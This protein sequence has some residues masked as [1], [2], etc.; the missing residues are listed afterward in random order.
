MNKYFGF[1]ELKAASIPTVPWERFSCESILDENLLW[2]IRVAVEDSNDLNLPR[3]IGAKAEEAQKTGR[4]YLKKYSDNGLVIYY[5][6]FLADKSGVLEISSKRIVIEAV[7]KD[8]WNLVTYGKRDVTIII[9]ALQ[10]NDNADNNDKSDYNRNTNNNDNAYHDYFIRNKVRAEFDGDRNFL[11]E[12]EITDLLRNVSIMKGRFR[13]EL[14]SGKSIFAEWSYAYNTDI[15]Q[16][17]IGERYLVFY[18][19]RTV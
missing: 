3:I 10:D 19:L 6:Y 8:L 2:T 4:E 18:E 13:D 11:N 17:P 15:F 14:S 5:P 9:P 12:K 16:K 1:Y 7:E